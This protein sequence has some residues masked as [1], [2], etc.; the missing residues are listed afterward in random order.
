MDVHMFMMLKVTV[1][2]LDTLLL[3][4]TG[5][6]LMCLKCC[7]AA[8][9]MVFM[10]GYVAQV[11]V[12]KRPEDGSSQTRAPSL[13]LYAK[14]QYFLRKSRNKLISRTMRSP[15]KS[16]LPVSEYGQTASDETR[17]SEFESNSFLK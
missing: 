16:H 14:P 17:N 11:I 1:H 5:S 3:L 6:V 10:Q 12:F 15:V 2:Y 4:F 9:A 8:H 13:S 7:L